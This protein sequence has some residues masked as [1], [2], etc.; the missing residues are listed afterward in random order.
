MSWKKFALLIS[1]VLLGGAY[2]QSSSSSGSQCP[3]PMFLQKHHCPNEATEQNALTWSQARNTI[4]NTRST[5]RNTVF[6]GEPNYILQ[7][8]RCISEVTFIHGMNR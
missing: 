7:D 3:H 2:Q 5:K 6:F 8:G 1:L 4:A